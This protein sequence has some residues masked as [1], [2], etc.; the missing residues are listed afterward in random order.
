MKCTETDVLCVGQ[1]ALAALAA[2]E[3]LTADKAIKNETIAFCA[4]S[5]MGELAR[6]LQM[7]STPDLTAAEIAADEARA[8]VSDEGALTRA[9][10]AVRLAGEYPY[11]IEK[12]MAAILLQNAE[13]GV[14]LRQTLISLTG[15]GSPDI[16]YCILQ[17]AESLKNGLDAEDTARVDYVK[18]AYSIGFQIEQTYKGCGQCTIMAIDHLMGTCH[19]DVFLSATGFSGGMALCGDGV[20]G[21]Y[22]GGMMMLCLQQGR[23]LAPMKENG[24]KENQYAGYE[25]SQM[26]HDKF[27]ACYGSPICEKI[28]EGMFDGESFILRTKE[29]RNEFEEAGAHKVV[30]TTVVALACAWVAEILVDRGLVDLAKA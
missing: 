29:R 9:L 13:K 6:A 3:N 10:L 28:H 4:N 2:L 12:T 23:A 26:L 5:A 14:D 19:E 30:C 7:E 15:I 16:L 17:Q 21:G 22:A 11:Y 24:D 27:V 20:C 8:A 25:A 18:K 1:Q